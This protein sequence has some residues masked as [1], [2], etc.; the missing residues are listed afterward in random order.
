M[1]SLGMIIVEIITG[2]PLWL[3]IPSKV[4]FS[5]GKSSSYR[6]V[7][8][9]QNRKQPT[10]LLDAQKNFLKNFDTIIKGQDPYNLTKNLGLMDLVHKMLERDAKTRISPQDIMKH[11]FISTYVN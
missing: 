5:N 8:K 4:I 1:W 3:P 11:S 7:F 2:V 9:C 10:Q 6:G